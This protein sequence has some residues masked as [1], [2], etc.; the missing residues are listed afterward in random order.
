M[1]WRKI[2]VLLIEDDDVDAEYIVR[3]LREL[4]FPNPITIVTNGVEAIHVLRGDEAHKPLPPPYAILLD[5][6]TPTM[7]GREFLEVVRQ[8]NELRQS[9]IF[10]VTNSNHE[11][12]KKAAYE[13][14]VAGYF[15]KDRVFND[16]RTL[17]QFL[18]SYFQLTEFPISPT[19][20]S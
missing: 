11:D 14:Q 20:E 19:L 6:Y 4:E 9:V 5:L 2:H 12:D 13:K 16:K 15:L 18:A 17:P 1:P 8:D 3:N 10:V 7:N